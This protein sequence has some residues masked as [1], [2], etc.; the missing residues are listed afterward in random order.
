MGSDDAAAYL[1][2][3]LLASVAERQPYQGADNDLLL[4]AVS[5]SCF[6]AKAYFAE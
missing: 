6:V 4:A 5:G 3:L 2:Q 1:P